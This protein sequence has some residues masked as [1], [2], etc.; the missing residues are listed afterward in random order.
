[1]KDL[2]EAYA[3]ATFASMGEAIDIVIRKPK[4]DAEFRAAAQ[5]MG[6]SEPWVT[7][8]RTPEL[9][10]PNLINPQMEVL[11]AIAGEEVVG[12]ISMAIPIPLISAELRRSSE[13]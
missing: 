6:T 12:I 4:G 8:G 2:I 7:L 13:P 5:I 11:L 3:A 10:H 9:I 1:M